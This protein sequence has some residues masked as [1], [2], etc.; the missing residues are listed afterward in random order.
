M[1]LTP[2]MQQ[3]FQIKEQY[4]DC[5]LFYR[6][7]DFYE[8]FFDDALLA[9]KE[10]EIT[11]T[12]RDCG[13][14]ERAPMCG[15]P[16]HA[17]D[18]YIARLVEKGY[19]VAICEQLQD[20][21]QAKGIVER[22]IIRIVTPGTVS[23]NAMLGEKENNY[24]LS[25]CAGEGSAYGVAY[26]DVSTGAF[27]AE[28]AED[29]GSLTALMNRL[30]AKEAVC[31][32]DDK[33][34]AGFLKLSGSILINCY[35]AWA[36][37]AET[38]AKILKEHFAVAGLSVFGLA[39]D[40]KALV[41]ACGALMQYLTETQKN[42]LG[43]I[44]SLK[45]VSSSSYMTIDKF[46]HRNLELTET[47]RD[48]SKKG[49]LLWLLDKTKT[50]MGGR[51]IKTYIERPLLNKREITDRL[52]A[53]DELK[54]NYVLRS[55]LR[56]ALGNVYDIER[57]L[58]KISYQT[59]D[60]RHALS[61]LQSLE[62]FPEIKELLE[63]CKSGLLKRLG[64]QLDPLEGLKK[65]LSSAI[66]ENPPIGITDGGIIK[67][68]FHHEVDRLRTAA[69]DGATWLKALEEREREST[70]I[71]NLKVGYNKVFG[72][73]IEV[74]KSNLGQVPYH[75]T[76]RQTLAGCERFITKELKDLEDTILSAKDR[77][78]KL[79]YELFCTIRA[80]I[81]DHIAALQKDAEAIA[82]VD[83]LQSFA[84]AAYD[85]NYVKP[86]IKDDGIIEIKNGRHPVVERTVNQEFVPNDAYL[87][88]EKNCLLVI[89]GPNMAGKST[90]MR[91]VGLIILM[92]HMGSFVP[93]TSA[94]I[95]LVD[96]VFTRVGASDDLSSGQSTFMVEMNELASILNNA[97]EKSVLILDEIGRGTST[98]DGLSI[99]W[100][101]IEYILENLRA[102]TLFATHYHELTSLEGTLDGLQN[103]SISIRE[104]QDTVIFLHKIKRGGADRSFGIEVAKLAGLP[105]KLLDRSKVLLKAIEE[106]SGVSLDQIEIKEQP[107]SQAREADYS[108]VIGQ[109][110]SIDI[111]TLT[112]LESMAILA[113]LAE[114]VRT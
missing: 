62:Q 18:T 14:A 80:K 4:K 69:N 17:A 41:G 87:D 71:K 101:T 114:K 90:F 91:Q 98:T 105:A 26:A 10:L 27:F 32:E 2:M 5:I 112:P 74:T 36:F 86:K 23:D 6:L 104:L 106:S 81:S 56:Q 30:G 25:I 76:R 73:Y 50:A 64:N 55:A 51:L 33:E 11:L 75:Y 21:S 47:M 1:A 12:G 109:L 61:I 95:C 37:E 39:E 100:A 35:P 79:E 60:G 65:L 67:E 22:G 13:L 15:V 57:L 43:H 24:I 45:V 9:S 46:T 83:V 40:N 85:Y 94:E 99:A 53:V 103:Y 48:K 113:E 7:G 59:L 34:L 111:N 52:N 108:R 49:S 107:A 3:Y 78:A 110:R 38:A 96:R 88:Q 44:S 89:T 70:G 93:A 92:A 97:T 29:K 58:T 84:Q 19:K 28:E 72:Y 66:I 20:P 16:F 68:G 77:L 63:G 82:A 54:S 31:C 42:T 8:M 102:K